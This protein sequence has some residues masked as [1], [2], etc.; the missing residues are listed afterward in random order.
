MIFEILLLI[1]LLFDSYDLY[2]IIQFLRIYILGNAIFTIN[3]GIKYI[4]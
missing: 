1:I 4:R 2:E 3:I